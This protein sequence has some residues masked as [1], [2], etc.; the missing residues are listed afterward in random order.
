MV[1]N[2]EKIELIRE[3]MKSS[4]DE[5]KKI[6]DIHELL[7]RDTNNGK[8][9]KYRTVKKYNLCCIEEGNLF[10]AA[11]D[12]FNDPFDSKIGLTM[13]SIMEAQLGSEFDRIR[14]ILDKT[15]SVYE[16]EDINQY[17][18]N[19]KRAI[20]DLLTNDKFVGFLE[21]GKSLETN[22]E[23]VEI[24][25][26]AIKTISKSNDFQFRLKNAE[27]IIGKM[28]DSF[29]LRC[30][31]QE[32]YSEDE[33]LNLM[34]QQK[35]LARDTD[36][37]DKMLLLGGEVVSSEK[38]A[39]AQ[40]SFK[41]LEKIFNERYTG[42]FRIGC[43]ATDYKNR[44][45]W[46]HYANSH[47]GYC[48]EYDYGGEEFFSLDYVPL[49]VIYSE[50]RLQ[51]P[52]KVAFDNTKENLDEANE[53]ILMGLLSKD[54]AWEYENE[55]RILLPAENESVCVKMPPISCVYLG[56]NMN[57]PNKRKLKKICRELGI[58]VKQMKV[59]RGAYELHAESITE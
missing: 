54:Q 49:P 53:Q 48:V 2:Q 24:V 56:A 4:I 12:S 43:L 13:R 10:C 58:E 14:E 32:R 1:S 31:S 7:L 28:V 29:P 8:L 45:M 52:W 23:S 42:L 21:D 50:Q 35:G 30:D 5:K 19:E 59:D 33:L 3:F 46:S 34:L 51:V 20:R 55:W 17:S 37:I 25:V 6:K 40:N 11:A 9:Y 22:R 47:S 16:G 27:D 26:N 15:L 39:L 41:E 44:L 57:I 18:E 36:E 38:I